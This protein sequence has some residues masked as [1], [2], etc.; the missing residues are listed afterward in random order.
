ML[1]CSIK[2]SLLRL[3][4]GDLSDME[5]EAIVFYA[6][7]DLVL[8]AG[9]GNAITVRGGMSIQEELK[10]Y[11][12]ISICEAVVTGAGELK[13]K[14]IIHAVGPKFQET[15]TEQKLRTTMKN[16]LL[17]AEEKGIRKIGFPPMGTGFYGIPL[18]MCA[19]IMIEVIREHLSSDTCIDE[20]IIYLMDDREF[21]PFQK[22]FKR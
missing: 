9:F 18:D 1:E 20:V 14:H 4:K 2:K 13:C 3:E 15:D 21:K 12:S 16:V 22:I 7:K 5:I 19:R 6:R 11:G 17:L 10:N 8:G